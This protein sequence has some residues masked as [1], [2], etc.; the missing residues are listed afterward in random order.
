M[1]ALRLTN[2]DI[3]EAAELYELTALDDRR[4]PTIPECQQCRLVYPH[5]QRMPIVRIETVSL[6]QRIEL[7]GIEPLGWG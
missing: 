1:Q 2:I 6:S 5:T 7:I 3:A 4:L